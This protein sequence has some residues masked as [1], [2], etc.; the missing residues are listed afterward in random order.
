MGKADWERV[1]GR[2]S[3]LR[4]PAIEHSGRIVAKGAEIG[5]ARHGAGLLISGFLTVACGSSTAA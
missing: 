1:S 5:K 4:T 3:V 2:L